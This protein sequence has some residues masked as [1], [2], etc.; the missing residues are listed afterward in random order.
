M[1]APRG[2]SSSAMY[3]VDDR[4][5]VVS[6]DDLP[7]PSIGAP[8]PLIVQDEHA[9]VVAFYTH[10]PDP[11]WTGEAVRIVDPE[12]SNEPAALVRFRGVCATMLGPPNDEAFEGHPLA[13]R[14]LR[15]Y[16]ASEVWHSSWIRGLERMSSVHP[17]H[18]P[19]RYAALRHFV[20]AFHDSTFE[21]V[22]SRYDFRLADGPLDRL[23]QPMLASLRA[24]EPA[25]H[26]A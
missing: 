16:F 7:Q 12:T 8:C 21:C 6:M 13:E 18:R 24:R 20:L 26:E 3:A 4:D 19:E 11:D 17:C 1:V 25:G 10:A 23:V 9:A 14:G 5:R 22:A 2:V 15:P